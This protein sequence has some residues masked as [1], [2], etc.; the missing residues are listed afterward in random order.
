MMALGGSQRFQRS[1]LGMPCLW[2]VSEFPQMGGEARGAGH[3]VLDASP[4][5]PS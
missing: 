1:N 4:L 2:V 5:P 3:G